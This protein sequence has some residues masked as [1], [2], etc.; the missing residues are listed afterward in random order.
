MTSRAL[1][2]DVSRE[3]QDRLSTFVKL[4]KTWN[5][6]INLVARTD[7]HDLWTRH[8]ADS[9]QVFELSPE[10]K[11]SWLDLGSGGG[12]PGLVVAIVAAEKQPD[13]SVTLIES[14]AR[15]SAF[16]RTVVR[17]AGL[18]TTVLPTRI[19][20][21]SP[22][23]ADVISARALAALTKLLG[24][25]SRHGTPNTTYLFPKGENW[26]KEIAEAQKTWRFNAE[27]ITSRT[28]ENAVILRLKEVI[29][30]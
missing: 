24:L 13:L 27:P 15:K 6:A 22:Q 19:E 25:A 17:E 23:G 28:N 4:L 9:L 14:D 2:T 21:A 29:H 5:Q 26:K 12:F 8:V 11:Q 30:V 1:A 7:E 10:T 20:R 18:K 16:L 3:T